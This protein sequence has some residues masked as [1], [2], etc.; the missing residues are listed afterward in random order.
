MQFF[1]ISS[2]VVLAASS[3][4]GLS[5]AVADEYP[6]KPIKIILATGAGGSADQTIRVI[7]QALTQRWNQ[8]LVIEARPGATGMIAAEAAAKSAPDGY[9][10][11]FASTTFI[12]APALFSKVPYDFIKDFAPVSRAV[13]VTTVLAVNANSPIK[14][15]D[16]YIAAGRDPAK[17]IA[18]GSIGIGSSPH[19]YGAAFSKESKTA[20][21]HVTYR[22]EPA[23]I[24]DI[25]GGHLDSAFLTPATATELVQ[26]GKLRALA[27]T[28]PSRIQQMLETPTFVEL[29]FPR[30]EIA[31]WFGLLMPAGTS[32]PIVVKMSTAITEVLNTPD[33]RE[34]IIKMGFEPV[35]STPEGFSRFILDD[36]S[37]WQ[38]MIKDIG[39]SLQP[40]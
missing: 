26:A 19:I 10:A 31:G 12:Q 11:L 13:S 30:L 8:P 39:I 36:F 25:L 21:T 40:Q 34:K 27:V 5:D 37:K 18:Y 38:A 22:S 4:C 17:P 14:S 7:G 29:G 9:T 16:D 23:Q 6:S 15:L 28:G 1:W 20:M 3:V 2:F 32:K 33:V 35:N 24:T